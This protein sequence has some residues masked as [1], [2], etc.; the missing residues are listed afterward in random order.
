MT[1]AMAYG[2]A[3]GAPEL[4]APE[5]EMQPFVAAATNDLSRRLR[6]ENQI[7]AADPDD[8]RVHAALPPLTGNHV[9]DA[10]SIH[11]TTSIVKGERVLM[12]T[13]VFPYPE[14]AF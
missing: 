5:D 6:Q 10:E 12:A 11:W 13:Y 9:I 2:Y 7:W 1:R 8:N 14:V 4:D 3:P